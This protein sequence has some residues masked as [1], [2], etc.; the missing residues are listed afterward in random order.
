M[1]TGKFLKKGSKIFEIIKVTN[2]SFEE[3]SLRKLII[4]DNIQSNIIHTR[5]HDQ[6]DI[7]RNLI[8]PSSFKEDL[9]QPK[10]PIQFPIDFTQDWEE[11]KRRS[12]RPKEHDEDEEEEYEKYLET[13]KDSDAEDEDR[14]TSQSPR[15]A[16]R[17]I[18][19][20]DTI[21]TIPHLNNSADGDKLK[22]LQSIE[23]SPKNPIEIVKDAFSKIKTEPSVPELKQADTKPAQGAEATPPDSSQASKIAMSDSDFKQVQ[24]KAKELGYKEGLEEALKLSQQLGDIMRGLE[25]LKKDVLSNIQDNFYELVKALSQ[26]IFE[27]EIAASPETFAKII[28]KTVASLIDSDKFVVHLNPNDFYKLSSLNADSLKNNLVSDPKISVGNFQIETDLGVVDTGLK[29]IINQLLEQTNL[30]LFDKEKDSDN[31]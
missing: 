15:K 17:E 27:K 29:D 23:F 24:E 8:D 12:I 6:D 18:P 19:A 30:S 26:T 31:R 5:Y 9:E 25:R 11:A 3:I 28:R 13:L 21:E 22:D 10:K 1:P 7:D 4:P 16:R 2:Y 14:D 20:L